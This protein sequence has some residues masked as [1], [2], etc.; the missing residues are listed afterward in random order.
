MFGAVLLA[1][2]LAKERT[3][4]KAGCSGAANIFE[5]SGSR[6]D[7][8]TIVPRLWNRQRRSI[9]FAAAPVGFYCPVEMQVKA[10][11]ALKCFEIKIRLWWRDLGVGT[12]PPRP[13]LSPGPARRA[14][15]KV[16][17]SGPLYLSRMKVPGSRSL[18]VCDSDWKWKLQVTG[19]EAATAPAARPGPRCRPGGSKS[20]TTTRAIGKPRRSNIVHKVEQYM[21]YCAIKN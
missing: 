9:F 8:H 13:N 12:R 10:E 18:Q 19:G 2:G 1:P 17:G 21:Q 7:C 20:N 3:W 16:S 14:P 5:A 4:E 15:K 11:Q 6:R